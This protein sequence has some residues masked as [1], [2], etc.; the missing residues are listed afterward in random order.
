MMLWLSVIGALLCVPT[1][2]AQALPRDTEIWLSALDLSMVQQ[3]WG[4]PHRD[5]SVEGNPLSIGGHTYEH[6]LGT[7]SMGAFVLDLQGG[8]RRFVAEV[9]IDDETKGRGSAEFEVVADGKFVWRSGVMRGGQEAKPVDLNLTGVRQ[10]VLVVDDAG[11]G[12]EFDHADWA[13]ARFEGVGTPP[14]AIRLPSPDPVVAM[15]APPTRPRFVGPAVVGLHVGTPALFTLAVTGARPMTFAA[16]GLPSGLALNT[17]TG[18]VTGNVAE[19]GEKVVTFY[20][21]N[22]IGTASRKVRVAAG[23]TVALTPPMGWNSYDSYGDDVTEAEILANA[24][25]ARQ[26]LQPYGWEYVVVDYRWYDPN[27]S[28]APNDANAQRDATLTMDEFGRL[29]PAANRFPSAAQGEG[30]R[31]L[32]DRIHSMGLKFGIHIMRGIPRQAVKANTPIEGSTYT[33][34]DAANTTNTCGWCPDMFGVETTKSAG[35]AWYDSLMRLYASWGVDLIKVDDMSSPYATGEIEAVRA[36]IEK[37]GRAIVLSLSPGET[38]VDQAEHVKA[39]ANMWRISGDFWDDW[40]ALSHQ[41]DLIA[42]WNGNGGP[43]HW[44]DADMI[45]LG[46]L[47]IH[48][49]SVGADRRTNLTKNE[50]LTLMTLWALA[51]SP[52]ML[53]MNLPDNDAWTLA[54]LTNEEVLAVNQDEGGTQATRITQPGR[55]GGAEVWARD[56][57][58]GSKAVGLF[59]RMPIPM[60]VAVSWTEV[61]LTGN[62]HVRDL[63]QHRDLGVHTDRFEASVPP[64]GA[65]LIRLSH[66]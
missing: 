32:A 29:T 21:R 27:A 55:S 5:R 16:S 22:A 30:F 58:D 37:C 34:A 3:G 1:I 56:L 17:G 7:H 57:A 11:D 12:F 66:L 18:Q 62:R 42:R 36:A 61:G 20:A 4:T 28:I 31:P 25:Y 39:H 26:N 51:P 24:Q 64:H 44:P 2:G 8:S 14:R 59:N 52:L 46:H 15:P 40:G 33:A 9:G 6:G 19:A 38:P 60:P 23:D 65:I 54:L 50:Q 47:S 49:R 45:P 13:D 48:N 10:L 53:G 41:F 35:Q 43:G 63:W